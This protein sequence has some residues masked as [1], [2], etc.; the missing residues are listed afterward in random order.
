[1]KANELRQKNLVNYHGKAIE[2]FGVVGNVIYYNNGKCNDSNIGDYIAFEP[3][4]LTPEWLKRF[5]FE[6]YRHIK[7]GIVF[8]NSWLRINESMVA[9]W[10]GAYIDKLKYVHQ[11]QNLFFCLCGKELEIKL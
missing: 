8:D 3:I 2:V 6:E 10:R 1:M 11:L 4:P 9:Y 5:G 7:D